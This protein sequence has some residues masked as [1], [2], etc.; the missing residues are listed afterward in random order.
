VDLKRLDD[1]TLVEAQ[2]VRS[3]QQ[4]LKLRTGEDV[5]IKLDRPRIFLDKK[6]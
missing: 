3:R 5:F 2:L 1:H 4:E 6:G